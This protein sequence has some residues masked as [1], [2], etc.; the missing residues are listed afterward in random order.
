MAQEYAPVTVDWNEVDRLATHATDHLRVA[1]DDIRIIAQS[2]GNQF[3]FQAR[4]IDNEL[5]VRHAWAQM[6]TLRDMARMHA[7]R[8][9]RDRGAATKRLTN[10]PLWLLGRDITDCDTGRLPEDYYVSHPPPVVTGAPPVQAVER[11]PH[12]TG[13][14]RIIENREERRP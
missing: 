12:M 2:Y 3:G 9:A 11:A 1:L 8:D 14:M 4:P 10:T 6:Q 5:R 13:R 7:A